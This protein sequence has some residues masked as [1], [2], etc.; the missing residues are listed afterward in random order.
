MVDRIANIWGTRTPYPRDG[1]WPVRSLDQPD[2]IIA[3]QCHDPDVPRCFA[4]FR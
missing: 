1:L 2:R 3:V 4:W